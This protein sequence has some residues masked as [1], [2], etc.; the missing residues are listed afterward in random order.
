[1]RFIVTA[2]AN[3]PAMSPLIRRLLIAIVL[4]A[5]VVALFWWLGRPKPI[6]VVV[7]TID[8]GKVE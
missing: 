1:M 2:F 7:K 5:A 6:A 3:R 4:I 8:R